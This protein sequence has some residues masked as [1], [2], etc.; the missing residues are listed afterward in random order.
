MKKTSEAPAHCVLRVDAGQTALDFIGRFFQMTRDEAK[1]QF[2]LYAV[3]AVD[4]IEARAVEDYLRAAPADDLREAAAW[5]E[6]AAAIPLALPEAAPSLSLR[7][8]LLDR[9]AMEAG[10]MPVQPVAEQTAKILPFKQPIRQTAPGTQRWLLMAASLLLACASAI[11][12]WRNTQIAGER[13]SLVAQRNQIASELERER[14]E[15]QDLYASLKASSKIVP[16]DGK[17]TPQANAKVVWDTKQQ[18]LKIFILD[19]PSPPSDKDYQLWYVTKKQQKISAQVFRP[20]SSGR[21]V[22]TLTLPREALAGGLAAT[23]VTLEPRGGS[24][25]PTGKFYLLG[26]I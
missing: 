18:V 24:P 10:A 25:Q 12:W 7:S 4:E 8:R 6:V 16:M 3:G 1:E 19:L 15:K 9:I 11:L 22:L 20:E 23:A 26:Q 17:E 5:S 13:D 2:A 14:S 21:M